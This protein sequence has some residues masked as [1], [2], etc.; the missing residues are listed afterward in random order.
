MFGPMARQS[1]IEKLVNWSM[2][3]DLLESLMDACGMLTKGRFHGYWL[4]PIFGEY[5]KML[6]HFERKIYWFH[7]T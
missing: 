4:Y 5:Y 2:V 3:D 7:V 1:K 6:E